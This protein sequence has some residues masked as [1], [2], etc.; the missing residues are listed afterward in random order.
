MRHKIYSVHTAA[1]IGDR[2]CS[3]VRSRCGRTDK[4]HNHRQGIA[5]KLRA[6]AES[7]HERN[8]MQEEH[9]VPGAKIGNIAACGCS[10]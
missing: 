7:R 4:V 6:D 3:G 10:A 9:D 5:R 1:R 2:Q 8:H